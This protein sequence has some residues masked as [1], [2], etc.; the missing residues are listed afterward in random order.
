MTVL[1]LEEDEQTCEVCGSAREDL[2]DCEGVSCCQPCAEKHGSRL[3]EF[4]DAMDD[5]IRNS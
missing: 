5:D 3:A 1:V 2:V 4:R